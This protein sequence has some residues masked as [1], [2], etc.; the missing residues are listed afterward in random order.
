MEQEHRDYCEAPIC[1]EDD[2]ESIWYP[3]EGV[4]GRRPF[5]VFQK[6]QAKLNRLFEKGT[7]RFP[8]GYWTRKSLEKQNRISKGSK[9]LNPDTGSPNRTPLICK[10]TVS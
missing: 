6:R 4:C 5:K 3:G 7:L 8:S 2:T 1:A 10:K 9:G